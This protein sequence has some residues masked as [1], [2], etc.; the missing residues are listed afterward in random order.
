M[1][2]ITFHVQPATQFLTWYCNGKLSFSND[3]NY[4]HSCCKEIVCV[5]DDILGFVLRIIFQMYRLYV[6][7]T[8][9]LFKCILHCNI[10][11]CL[12]VYVMFHI[13]L[14]CDSQGSIECMYV[15]LYV[16]IMYI[17]IMYVCM[18]ICTYVCMYVC[19]YVCV[20]VCMY[21]CM[22]VCMYVC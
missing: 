16:C 5:R 14:P 12:Y 6:L 22:C 9:W 7:M 15:W 10:F 3:S 4:C 1:L 2:E 20:Y 18:Y 11:V 13:L 17:C 19:M 8:I 21:V